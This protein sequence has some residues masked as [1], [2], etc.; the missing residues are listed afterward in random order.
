MELQNGRGLACEVSTLLQQACT[1]SSQW[2]SCCLGVR[3]ERYPMHQALVFVCE[4][5]WLLHH[6]FSNHAIPLV[7]SLCLCGPSPPIPWFYGLAKGHVGLW[8]CGVCVCYVCLCMYNYHGVP[9]SLQIRCPELTLYFECWSLHP[10]TVDTELLSQRLAE[11]HYCLPEHMHG[12]A[13]SAL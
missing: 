2:E 1:L 13:A 10:Q 7:I 5:V 8:S 4:V 6:T 12:H 11:Y 3:M 9:S